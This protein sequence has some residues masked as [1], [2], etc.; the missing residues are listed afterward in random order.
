MTRR[1]TIKI[2]MKTKTLASAVFFAFLLGAWH[3][4]AA[5][6]YVTTAGNDGNPGNQG[7]PF[8]TIRKA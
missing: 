8:R 3:A 5:T 1:S 6:Y 7:Q 2:F 4:S